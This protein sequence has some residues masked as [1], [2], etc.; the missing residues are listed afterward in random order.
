MLRNK[1]EQPLQRRKNALHQSHDCNNTTHAQSYHGET[2]KEAYPFLYVEML[3]R[4]RYNDR[5][6]VEIARKYSTG[7]CYWS[8]WY[9]LVEKLRADVR[10]HSTILASFWDGESTANT[11]KQPHDESHWKKKYCCWRTKKYSSPKGPLV[12]FFAVWLK[13][14][15]LIPPATEVQIIPLEKSDVDPPRLLFPYLRSC[16]RTAAIRCINPPHIYFHF[17]DSVIFSSMCLRLSKISDG[18]EI[19]LK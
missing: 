13:E 4:K 2:E 17:W 6:Q 14:P 1:K 12:L 9:D 16:G 10:R 3:H 15:K 19:I 5:S 7:Q 11:D 8:D 18:A